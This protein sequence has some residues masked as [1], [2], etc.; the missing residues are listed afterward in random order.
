MFNGLTKLQ[1]NPDNS[2]LGVFNYQQPMETHLKEIFPSTTAYSTSFA[3]SDPEK[4]ESDLSAWQSKAN[5]KDERS[6]LINK[7][8]SETGIS[9]KKEFTKLLSNEFA[10]VTTRFHERIA[11]I[12]VKDGSRIRTLLGNISQMGDNNTG[13]FNYEKIPQLLLGEAFSAFKKP[14]FKVFDNYL[15]LTNSILEMK[16]YDDSYNNRKFLSKT[17][18][19]SQFDKLL[20]E[21]SNVSFFIQLKNALQL[22]K[23]DM[24]PAFYEAFEHTSPG[25]K[26]YYAAAWQLTSSDKNYYTNF[27][28]Q[29]STDTTAR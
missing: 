17:D 27:C 19:Y 9:L 3:V 8:K 21:R 10:E 5:L 25:W 12:Q 22:F 20:S 24:K 7:V 29:L 28:M 15:V 14:Y 26:D 2:Y 11:I 23:E 4:F 6:T 1:D 18:G 16:S 13:L